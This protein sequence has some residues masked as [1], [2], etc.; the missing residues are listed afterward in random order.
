MNSI[1]E[2][3]LI[4]SQDFYH[5]CERSAFAAVG[6]CRQNVCLL[7]RP[8]KFVLLTCA[9]LLAVIRSAGQVIRWSHRGAMWRHVAP[10]WLLPGKYFNV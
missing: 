9:L 5:W 1:I 3:Y 2:C 8:Y 4:A 6:H 10:R 7:H